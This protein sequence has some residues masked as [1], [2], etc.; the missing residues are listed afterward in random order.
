MVLDEPHVRFYAGF[1]VQGR[2][3]HNV[4]TLC[5]MDKEPRPFTEGDRETLKDL[6]EMVE[7][8]LHAKPGFKNQ[9][10]PD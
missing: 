1:P 2:G 9:A 3:G 5:I 6:A 7:K 4:G 10:P 8:E